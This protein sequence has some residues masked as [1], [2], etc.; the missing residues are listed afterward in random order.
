MRFGDLGNTETTV[1]DETGRTSV[2]TSAW[3]GLHGQETTFNRNNDEGVVFFGGV[4][5]VSVDAADDG[6][7]VVLW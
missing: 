4:Y 3:V 7:L 2:S 1:N 6:E 5:G